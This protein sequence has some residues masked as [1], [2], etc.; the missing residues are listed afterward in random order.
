MLHI[1]CKTERNDVARAED[2]QMVDHTRNHLA[3]SD[4]ACRSREVEPLRD[5]ACETE[6]ESHEAVRG[7]LESELFT[8]TPEV[9]G[10]VHC[11]NHV[12][13]RER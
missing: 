11:A 7:C 4:K 12:L 1:G 5:T 2:W 3:H 8:T 13:E 9:R 6:K 10:A